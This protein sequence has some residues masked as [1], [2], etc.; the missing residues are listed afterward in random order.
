MFMNATTSLDYAMNAYRVSGEQ[1]RSVDNS[2][3]QFRRSG[4]Q[5]NALFEG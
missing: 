4:S 2:P 5:L 3:V 1:V